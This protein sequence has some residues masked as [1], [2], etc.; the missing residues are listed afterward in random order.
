MATANLAPASEVDLALSSV[1]SRELPQLT[2]CLPSM[3]AACLVLFHP[4][5]YVVLGVLPRI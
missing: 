2:A 1:A 4:S 5:A 3:E